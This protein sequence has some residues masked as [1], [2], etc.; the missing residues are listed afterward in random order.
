MRLDLMLMKQLNMNSVRTAHYPN[1]PAFYELCDEL[2]MYV[3][4]EANVESHGAGWMRENR[5]AVNVAWR[6]VQ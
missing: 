2:G 3:F 1:H 6:G 5:I 4:D